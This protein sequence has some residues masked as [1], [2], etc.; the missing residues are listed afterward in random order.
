MFMLQWLNYI[1][2]QI[3]LAILTYGQMRLRNVKGKMDTR[4]GDT[5]T[6]HHSREKEQKQ[7]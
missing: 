7:H 6:F 5:S 4:V 2:T 1:S 3:E